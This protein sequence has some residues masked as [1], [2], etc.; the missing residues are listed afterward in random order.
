MTNRKMINFLWTKEVINY[1]LDSLSMLL[2]YFY[3]PEQVELLYLASCLENSWPIIET[4]PSSF[5]VWQEG[6]I[7]E[8]ILSDMLMIHG[9]V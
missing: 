9:K 1:T 6:I 3:L 8:F 2:I 4:R 5:L 7:E